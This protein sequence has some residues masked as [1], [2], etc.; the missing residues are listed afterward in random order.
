MLYGKTPW[1]GA[2]QI[3]LLEN[4]KANPLNFPG[5][6]KVSDDSK[7]LMKK[8]LAYDE[9]SRINAADLFKNPLI[10]LK[11]TK[12]WNGSNEIGTVSMLIVL[13]FMLSKIFSE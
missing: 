8:M 1:Q 6:V 10:N 11:P 5:A 4:I 9:D 2:S 7:D 12:W 3:K 13:I